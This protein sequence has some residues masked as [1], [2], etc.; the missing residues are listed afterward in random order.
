MKYNINTDTPLV[1]YIIAEK[2]LYEVIGADESKDTLTDEQVYSLV[3]QYSP[4]LISKAE[5]LYNSN[6]HFRSQI[7][8]HKNDCRATLEMFMEHWS[9]GLLKIKN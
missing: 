5:R 3:M 2:V 6:E 7:N 4:K 8:S 9:K 1:P